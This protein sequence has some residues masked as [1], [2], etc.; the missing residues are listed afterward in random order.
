MAGSIERFLRDETGFA[1]ADALVAL[2][3]LA[4]TI[5]LSLEAAATAGRA[6]R[7]ALETRQASETLRQALQLSPPTPGVASGSTSLFAW[8][9]DTRSSG[10]VSNLAALRLC[11]RSASATSIRSRH[12]FSLA[13]TEPCVMPDQR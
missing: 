11:D 2:M 12:R 3:I 9:V 6:A 13:T 4:V 5:V 8:R 10:A 7:A 1:A